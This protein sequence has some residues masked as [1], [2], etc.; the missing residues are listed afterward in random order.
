M[1]ACIPAILRKMGGLWSR[2]AWLPA[3]SLFFAAASLG[4]PGLGNFVGE[5]L[6]LVGSYPS[7]SLA[8]FYRQCRIGSGSY[9]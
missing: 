2:M 9:L 5:F 1:N 8:R 4:L 6:I 3:I 7:C